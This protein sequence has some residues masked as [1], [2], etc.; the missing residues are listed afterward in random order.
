MLYIASENKFLSTNPTG[1]IVSFPVSKIARW[2]NKFEFYTKIVH[3][4]SISHPQTLL[5]SE[6]PG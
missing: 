3:I 5:S 4:F 6:T 2:Q 1:N